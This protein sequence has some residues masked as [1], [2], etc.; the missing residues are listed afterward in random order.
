[1]AS[2]ENAN[3]N[4]NNVSEMGY[5]QRGDHISSGSIFNGGWD[6]LENYGG[7]SSMVVNN[8]GLSNYPVQ[9]LL[10]HHHHHFQ[11]GHELATPTFGSGGGFSEMVNPFMNTNNLE[12]SQQN[13]S[14][15]SPLKRR[16]PHS[17]F[18]P[19]KN[20]DASGDSSEN[21]N[22]QN[23]KK[24]KTEHGLINS[25]SKGKQI[26]GKQAVKDNSDSGGA[27]KEDYIHVRAKRGQA[28]N[29]HSLAERV[30]RE[31]ISERMKLLQDLVPGCNKIT[32]KAVMLDEIINYVQSLQHQV[33]FLSMKLA[34]VNPELNVDI[35]QIMSKDI[36]NSR[37]PNPNLGFLTG[38]N[39]SQ[40]YAQGGLPVIPTSNPSFPTM[41]PQQQPVWD[42][43]LHNL[44]QM[45]FDNNIGP[46]GTCSKVTNTRG[47]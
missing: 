12:S 39:S 20:G 13:N 35:D 41:H 1:M 10:N 28:T 44:L 47:F 32:G 11:S 7:S 8:G 2:S 36:L 6:P 25:N 38:L 30:R 9:G 31:R 15:S 45:G 18:N 42:H 46:G 22:G 33:E 34:T 29:S 17:N 21:V 3:A 43:D 27:P 5:E 24:Q 19:V 26:G 23:E 4:N 16:P 37:G 14:A 40:H